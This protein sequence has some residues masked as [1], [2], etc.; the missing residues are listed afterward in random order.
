MNFNLK[1]YLPGAILIAL[2]ILIIAVPAILVV[3][4]AS[5][6]CLFGFAAL[7]VGHMIRKERIEIIR[8]ERGDHWN[9]EADFFEVHFGRIPVRRW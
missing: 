3:F 1:Y 6:L 8:M 2:S 9:R 5:V 7:Y 4:A